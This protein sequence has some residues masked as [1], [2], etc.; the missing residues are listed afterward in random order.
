M[1]LGV[2]YTNLV[3]FSCSK[4]YRG[5]V[6]YPLR[7]P[8]RLPDTNLVQFS[9]SLFRVSQGVPGVPHD[10]LG[11]PGSPWGGPQNTRCA[12]FRVSGGSLGS[13][14]IPWGSLGVPGGV[15]R[16]PDALFSEFLGGSLGVPYT[17][18]VQFSCSK[19]YRGRVSATLVSKIS[20]P[21]DTRNRNRN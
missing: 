4:H 3:Q 12:I 15:P 2:P 5:R 17:N 14:M 20:F 8:W 16:A 18:L 7:V 13:L 10:P 9:C 6:W 1:S 21:L 19:H 11:L